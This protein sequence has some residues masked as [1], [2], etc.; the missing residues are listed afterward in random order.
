MTLKDAAKY[1]LKR[2]L[3]RGAYDAVSR[4]YHRHRTR[5]LR[6]MVIAYL[7]QHADDDERREILAFLKKNAITPFP[8]DFVHEY[9]DPRMARAF[10]DGD[11][12]YVIHE[13]KRLYFPMAPNEAA[14]AYCALRCEQDPRSPHCYSAD[15]GAVP[16][17][18]D[19]IA[20]IGSAE[21]IWA[22]DNIETARRAYLFECE[23]RWIAALGK[24]FEPWKDKVEIV[25]R[26]VGSTDAPAAGEG[27][28]GLIRLDTFFR[29]RDIDCIKADIEG[30]EVDMLEGGAATFSERVKRAL[31]CAYHRQNDEAEIRSAL[32]RYG[33]E[34]IRTSRGYMLFPFDIEH[35]VEPYL[36]RGLVIATR[37]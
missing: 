4:L 3:P 8:Y 33:F 19:V 5:G 32:S 6:R 17:K 34:D 7:A 29:D 28:G 12:S 22:L 36:R 1:V 13:D 30:A 11:M 16:Q 37:S 25:N 24:T 20:D 31:I 14:W 27:G 10:E 18:G 2:V 15:K 21:A 23:D 26:Y 9:A 35:F